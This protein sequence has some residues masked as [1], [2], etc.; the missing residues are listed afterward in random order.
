MHK[1]VS[2]AKYRAAAPCLLLLC[3]RKSTLHQLMLIIHART[4]PGQLDL[5]AAAAGVKAT[6]TDRERPQRA[7]R[8]SAIRGKAEQEAPCPAADRFLDRLHR[9]EPRLPARREQGG[10]PPLNTKAG[11]EG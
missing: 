7:G 5:A 6:G 9:L 8:A 2:A 3:Y 10:N 11:G 1:S 4:V